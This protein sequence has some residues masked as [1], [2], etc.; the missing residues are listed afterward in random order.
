MRYSVC[1]I[2]VY[3]PTYFLSTEKF[4]AID[5]QVDAYIPLDRSNRSLESTTG[6]Y[7]GVYC[8]GVDDPKL[9]TTL[10][11]ELESSFDDKFR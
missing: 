1:M 4:L 8:R 7:H 10:R 9:A 2:S 11:Q 3:I 6:A 5:V